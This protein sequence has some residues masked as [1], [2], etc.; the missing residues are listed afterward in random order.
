MGGDRGLGEHRRGAQRPIAAVH[1]VDQAPQRRGVGRRPAPA[2]K[3]GAGIGEG[4][5]ER[6]V[7]PDEQRG[8]GRRF[9]LEP[10]GDRRARPAARGI[11]QHRRPVTTDLGD[12]DAGEALADRA[13]PVDCRKS[14]EAIGREGQDGTMNGGSGIA[15]RAS[16]SNIPQRADR[17]L[18]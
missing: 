2:G 6:G 3:I 13:R 7:D 5:G 17:S 8:I 1:L 14:R 11:A 18:K 15:A 4:Q 10:G 16:L 9:R 12:G